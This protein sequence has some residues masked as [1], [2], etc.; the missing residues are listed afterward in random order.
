MGGGHRGWGVR[1][2]HKAPIGPGI[3]GVRAPPPQANTHGWGGEGPPGGVG[4]AP[5]APIGVRAPPPTVG[6]GC[7]TSTHGC[8]PSPGGRVR[9]RRQRPGP[10]A[11]SFVE[12]WVEFRDKRAAKRAA[13]LLHGT[14][15]TPRPRSPFRH[16]CWS[17]KVCGGAFLGGSQTPGSDFLGEGVGCV[18]GFL[19]GGGDCSTFWGGAGCMGPFFWGGGGVSWGVTSVGGGVPFWGRVLGSFLVGMGRFWGSPFLGGGSLGPP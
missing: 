3:G 13:A 16:H 2:P 15:M 5:R 17:L 18:L 14:P 12:G 4:V 11:G 7:L 8:S 10:S 9:K 1:V 6:V 19:F